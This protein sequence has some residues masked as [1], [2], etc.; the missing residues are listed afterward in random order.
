[1]TYDEV[2]DLLDDVRVRKRLCLRLEKEI[3]AMR[4]IYDTLTCPLG[5][6]SPSR[7]TEISN[8]TERLALRV[9]DK[10]AEFEKEL[11][12]MM[13]LEDELAVAINLLPPTERDII[14][15]YYMQDETH[16][17]LARECNYSERHI[18]RIKKTATNKIWSK[19]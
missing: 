16:R 15:G 10:R 1:M 17:K 18:K 14:I 11:S 13:D 5:N 3:N 4:D 19:L 8:P 9:A 6:M 12:D 2:K 7:S